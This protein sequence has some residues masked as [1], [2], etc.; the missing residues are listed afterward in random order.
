MPTLNQ[1][2]EICQKS[3]VR[4]TPQAQVIIHNVL[5]SIV[6]DPHPTWNTDELTP[7]DAVTQ[8]FAQLPEIIEQITHHT[9]VRDGLVTT[10]DI[11]HWLSTS[12][13]GSAQQASQIPGMVVMRS[14]SLQSESASN[15][16]HWCPFSKARHEPFRSK[17][18][19]SIIA[20]KASQKS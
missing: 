19:K 13:S 10:F 8:L 17:S 6:E 14:I 1:I 3:S 18:G 4:F 15:L 11:L 16:D 9:T 20:E 5:T 12:A 2:A 7:L